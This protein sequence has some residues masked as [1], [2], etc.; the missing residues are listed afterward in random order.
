MVHGALRG[1]TYS[2]PDVVSRDVEVLP[3]YAHPPKK[4]ISTQEGQARLLHDLASI[5]LQAMELALRTL[6][7]F[8]EASREF[9]EQLA[10]LTLSEGKHLRLC[11]QGIEMLGFKW[12]DWPVHL[13]L[14]QAVSKEDS[15]LD[16]LLIVHRYLEGSGLDAS[17]SILK[18]LHGV[19]SKFVRQTVTTIFEEEID[20]VS[21]G[22]RWYKS[23]CEDQGFDADMDFRVRLFGLKSRLPMRIEKIAHES[24]VKAGFT[25]HQ[26]QT[27]EDFRLLWLA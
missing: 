7:E 19:P 9:R 17:E 25:P 4:G 18:K 20:H 1:N 21:F 3:P 15:L 12:G 2:I 6:V 27:L 13:G 10:D 24:R 22:S 14:W 16:R 11:L 26:I 23:F 8:P 5:E